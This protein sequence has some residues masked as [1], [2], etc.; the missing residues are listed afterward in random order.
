MIHSFRFI[1]I[2]TLVLPVLSPETVYPAEEA[3][4]PSREQQDLDFANGLYQRG[5]YEA[6][7]RQYQEFL[8]LYPKSSQREI[9]LFRRAE[10]L[11]QQALTLTKLNP[12]REKV[13][14]LEAQKAF[15]ELNQAFPKGG[16]WIEAQLRI[17]EIAYKLEKYSDALEPLRQVI[18]TAKDTALIEAAL[19]YSAR[20]HDQ[21]GRVETA[22]Q[23]Y[24]RLREEFRQGEYGA[25]STYLL[26]ELLEKQNQP[27]E[28][29]ELLNHLWMHQ[30]EYTFPENSNLLQDAQLRAAQMLYQMDQFA[31]AAKA[32]RAYVAL[33]P[34]GENAI[35][36]KYGAAWAEYQAKNYAETLEIIE[37]LQR[38]ALPPD[39]YIGSLFL[40]GTCS[41][42]QKF[43]DEAITAFR[44]VIANPNAGDYR[45]RAWYQLAWALYLSG[46]HEEAIQE[47]RNLLKQQIPVPLSANVH[48]LIGQAYS[49]M[50]QY[51]QAIPELQLVYQLDANSEYATD[52]LYLNADLLYRTGEYER[53]AKSFLL[54]ADNYP[55]AS[56][57]QEALLWAGNALFTAKDYP[58]AITVSERLLQQYP[59]V[60]EKQEVLYRK[61]LAHYQLKEYDPALDT[62][63]QVIQVNPQAKRV[64]DALYWKAYIYEMLE[65]D[66]LASEWY[67]KVMEQFPDFAEQNNVTLRK[68]LA[69]YRLGDTSGAYV[70]FQT[71]LESEKGGELPPEVVFWMIFQAREQGRH[72][73]AVAIAERIMKLF[74]HASV[75]ERA[76]LARIE[77]LVA[78]QKWEPAK[79]AAEGALTKYPETLFKPELYYN[80]AQAEEHL[81]QKDQ[82]L[83]HYE[84]ALIEATKMGNPDPGLEAN[85]YVGRGKLLQEQGEDEKALES[86]LRV[87][88][89]FDHEKLTPEAMYHAIRIH[90]K[91][92]ESAEAQTLKTEL[93]ERY[94]ESEWARKL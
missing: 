79:Q 72:E 92:N 26:A 47:A 12:P 85:L 44:E 93:L 29:S 61:A 5:M 53:A 37:S 54:Y 32:Y 86:F 1:L 89:L 63:D 76:T 48:F 56:R 59:K 50:E 74:D 82:A 49:R 22:E 64:A 13:L 78:L 2:L 84:T 88:I 39:L 21:L 19:F 75:Q 57:V 35:K 43:Y 40:K 91:L 62:F 24:R 38:S 11:Y 81:D 42:Q 51:Q 27:Q 55:A 9:A 52:A 23:Q 58:Q 7:A 83:E 69:D 30:E 4:A 6:A 65:N 34:T 90:Q 71:I 10:S 45:D 17:G 66:A 60:A 94:P 36:A 67:G 46:Q 15:A 8:S 68:A 41:Y 80:L 28:A 77:D 3:G 87:A 16:K 20:S 73:E 33:N 18:E 70:T 31:E 25:Y 14:Y